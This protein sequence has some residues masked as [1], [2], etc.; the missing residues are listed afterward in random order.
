MDGGILGTLGNIGFDWQVALVNLVNFLIIFLI[1]RHLAFKP[2]QRVIEKRQNIIKQGLLDAE[3]AKADLQ[4]SEVQGEGIISAAKQEANSILAEASSKGRQA[5]DQAQKD[6]L[7]ERASILA[8]A[9]KDAESVHAKMTD[10][11]TKEAVVLVISA[12]E[13]VLKSSVDQKANEVFIKKVL[14]NT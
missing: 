1:L 10:D 8:K 11:F 6:A 5:V 9:G 7:L 12:T 13:T 14:S 3:Q 2:I 4:S